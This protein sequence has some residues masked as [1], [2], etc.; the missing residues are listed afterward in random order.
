MLKFIFESKFN[1]YEVFFGFSIAPPWNYN[2]HQTPKL[3]A[4]PL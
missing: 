4:M 2:S 1:R 3:G